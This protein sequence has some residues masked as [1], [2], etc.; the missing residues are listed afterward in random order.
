M[1][2]ARIRW[3]LLL[4]LAALSS[5]APAAMRPP[6]VFS[7][8]DFSVLEWTFTEVQAG[9]G[10]DA[11]ADVVGG[12]NPGAMVQIETTVN[13][14]CSAI[15]AF[16]F[17]STATYSPAVEGSIESLDYDEDAR[18]LFGSGSGQATGLAI[19]Q[20]GNLYVM[21]GAITGTDPAW[22]PIPV[23]GLESTDFH[24]V[25]GGACPGYVDVDQHP[26]FSDGPAIEFGFFRAN[27]QIPPYPSYTIV[28]ALDNWEVTVHPMSYVALG[29][30]YSS[31]EGLWPYFSDS[32]F[33]LNECH[34]SYQAYGF[35]LRYPGV[36]LDED[37]FLPCSGATTY[38][39]VPG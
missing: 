26:N 29:D 36:H 25:L 28:A 15:Y 31:G 19:R 21:A 14:N 13:D 20:D 5:P 38:N 3:I 24:L 9:N 8:G 17:K 34:R 33:G 18:L 16:L 2:G 12:G 35:Q 1:R 27:S 22:H 37:A 39:L 11:T 30:S 10:G 6:I 32:L 4:S 7:D 23:V